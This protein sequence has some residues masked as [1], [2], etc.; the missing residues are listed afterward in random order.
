MSAINGG[1][2]A[3]RIARSQKIESVTTEAKSSRCSR[4]LDIALL[5][6]GAMIV[7]AGVLTLVMCASS[8]NA[9]GIAALILGS[10]C[11]GAGLSRIACRSFCSNLEA[12]NIANTRRLSGLIEA[13]DALTSIVSINKALL[14]KL[15]KEI[16]ILENKVIEAELDLLAKLDENEKRLL[17]DVRLVLSS[18]TRWLKASEQEKIVLKSSIRQTGASPSSSS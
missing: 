15:A 14:Q 4:I 16:Q 8:F 12:K 13:R 1:S 3:L 17:E 18:Y 6:V 11:L 9:L 7:V 5:V 10:A 2:S